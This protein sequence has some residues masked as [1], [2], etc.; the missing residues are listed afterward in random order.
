MKQ[1]SEEVLLLM[2]RLQ[3]L[4]NS[5]ERGEFENFHNRYQFEI[6]YWYQFKRLTDLINQQIGLIRPFHNTEN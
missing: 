1:M 6:Y 5:Y 2:E 4:H 3:R